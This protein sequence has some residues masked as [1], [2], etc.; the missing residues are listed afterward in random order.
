MGI[1]EKVD[2]YSMY[3]KIK[4]QENNIEISESILQIIWIY[5]AG[6]IK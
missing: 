6:E 3:S 5:N 4:D 2:R 1:Q